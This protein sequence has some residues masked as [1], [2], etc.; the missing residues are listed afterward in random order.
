MFF[1]GNRANRQ[2][3]PTRSLNTRNAANSVSFLFSLINL[4]QTKG[5]TE[6]H[7][8]TNQHGSYDLYNSCLDGSCARPFECRTS[9]T[10]GMSPSSPTTQTRISLPLT[11]PS[12]S[13]RHMDQTPQDLVSQ[14]YTISY[15]SPSILSTPS[16]LTSEGIS[17]GASTSTM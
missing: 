10:L 7:S 8:P 17:G 5:E 1:R 6:T 13:G 3:R 12:L 11:P 9:Q 15:L 14:E 4:R 2:T 16:S